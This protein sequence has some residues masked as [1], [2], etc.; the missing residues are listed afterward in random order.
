MTMPPTNFTPLPESIASTIANYRLGKIPEPDAAHVERWISQF[1]PAKRLLMLEELDHVLKRTHVSLEGMTQF[2][3][4]LPV[5]ATCTGSGNGK[6][7]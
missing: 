5:N 1:D 6:Q 7:L 4:S 2:L 3:G